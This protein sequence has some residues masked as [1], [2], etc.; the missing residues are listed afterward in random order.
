[1]A[2]ASTPKPRRRR[3]CVL[4]ALCAL[5]GVQAFAPTPAAALIDSRVGDECPPVSG[6]GDV[7]W[8]DVLQQWCGEPEGG[9]EGG[10]GSGDGGGGDDPEPDWPE[11][12][13]AEPVVVIHDPVA[14]AAVEEAH[15]PGPRPLGERPPAGVGNDGG[16]ARERSSTGYRA[17]RN[18]RTQRRQRSGA[19][20]PELPKWDSLD[21]AV[22]RYRCNELS[23]YLEEADEIVRSLRESSVG[24]PRR[25]FVP[26]FDPETLE[27]THMDRTIRN[28]NEAQEYRRQLVTLWGGKCEPAPVN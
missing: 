21:P 20:K 8:D 26:S 15:D 16:R 2:T 25:H 9:G 23:A 24:P 3:V 7:F 4:I 14:E 27:S 13:S 18:N 11:V 28:L 17:Q 12:P 6:G 10:G 22:R 1:M 19:K 5:V